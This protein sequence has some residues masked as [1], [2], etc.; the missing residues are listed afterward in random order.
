MSLSA[1]PNSRDGARTTFSV[2]D[3]T[4]H[5]I[6]PRLRKAHQAMLANLP[7]RKAADAWALEITTAPEPGMGSVAESTMDYA[8]AVHE[9]R[10]KDT[11]LFFFHR[12]ASDEHDLTTKDGA[13]AAV[14]EASG[15]AAKWRDI[16][17]IV[18]LWADPTTDRN[19]WQ[20]VW[21]NRLVRTSGHAFDSKLFKSL[22]VDE[23][24]AK[25]GDLITL[26]F[27]GALFRDA[28]ALVATH[29]E[30][31]Y[32][33]LA[34][35]WE[36][37]HGKPD[38][39]VPEHEVDDLVDAVFQRWSVWRLYADPPYWQ[40][41]IAHWAG[42]YGAERVIEWWTNRRVQTTRALEN[43]DTAM[44]QGA[45]SHDGSE[46]LVRHVAN[47]CRHDLPQI[48]EDGRHQWLI[49]KERSDSPLKIDAAMAAILSWEA[50]TDCVASG[51]VGSV[52]FAIV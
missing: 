8:R 4:H 15:E 2:F 37:P 14:L 31:G 24:P 44:K 17:A 42:K 12:Q 20:R 13:R 22:K 49:R 43:Y 6:L 26:G 3:E 29:V 5:W 38:W 47:A 9:G 25:D 50:R 18:E 33:W 10:A 7:K 32:Q 34:G 28:T 40:S 16:D 51:Q 19:Y 35:V 23:S 30:T 45:L 11:R 21:L 36:P 1:A 27:D 52:E 46:V 39:Q 41:W 48:G